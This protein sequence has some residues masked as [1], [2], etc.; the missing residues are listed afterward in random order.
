MLS[1]P[2]P[3]SSRRDFFDSEAE[4]EGVKSLSSP[5]TLVLGLRRTGK[6]SVIMISLSELGLPYI[7]VDLRKFEE[8]GFASYRDLVVELEREVNRLTSRFPGLLELLR[9]VEGVEVMG[10]GVRLRWGGRKRV[11]ISSLLKAL[12][13]WAEDRVLVVIDE[14]QELI[15][16]RGANLLPALAYSF[17]NLRRVRVVLS[18]SKMGLLY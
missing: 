6:S 18:G 9:R 14:A 12:N 5:I 17:D 16:M 2:V 11:T 8:K 10:S 1:D 3:K 7:Y 13:D 15:N 4:I